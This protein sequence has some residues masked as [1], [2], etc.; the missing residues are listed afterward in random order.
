[1]LFQQ[2]QQSS[3]VAPAA[4]LGGDPVG[5]KNFSNCAACHKLDAKR[6]DRL[7]EVLRRSMIKWLYKWIH[8]P[9]MIKSGDAAAVK[10][11]EENNKVNM[12][13]FPT[14]TETDIDNIIAYTSE[15]KPAA[16]AAV[17][18]TVVAGSSDQGGISNNIGLS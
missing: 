1:M 14:L 10:V 2:P 6:P 13:A 11:Y 17:P 15:E 5:V 3:T 9:A 12:T 16:P 8:N 7:L 18:G 4:T